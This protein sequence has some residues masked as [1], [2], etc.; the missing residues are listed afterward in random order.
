[1]KKGQGRSFVRTDG[2]NRRGGRTVMWSEYQP[3]AK[4]YEESLLVVPGILAKRAAYALFAEKMAEHG[5][6]TT[7]LAHQSGSLMCRQEIADT[8]VQIADRH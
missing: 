4:R 5:Y 8:A 2:E 1:M 3:L 6:N 7:L